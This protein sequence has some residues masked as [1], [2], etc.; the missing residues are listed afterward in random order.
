MKRFPLATPTRMNHTDQQPF[1]CRS[2]LRP[3]SLFIFFSLSVEDRS[4]ARN[5]WI[6]DCQQLDESFQNWHKIDCKIHLQMLYCCRFRDKSRKSHVHRNIS[7]LKESLLVL[8]RFLVFGVSGSAFSM[9]MWSEGWS[10][11]LYDFTTRN[12]NDANLLVEHFRPMTFFLY[13]KDSQLS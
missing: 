6:I 1:S 3:G 8:E 9:S 11:M 12:V 5:S 10:S 13:E 7:I 4:G 2:S